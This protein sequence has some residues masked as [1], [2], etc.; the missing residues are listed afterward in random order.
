MASNQLQEENFLD[1]LLLI[2]IQLFDLALLF[3]P[4]AMDQMDVDDAPSTTV[5]GEL[6]VPLHMLYIR[7]ILLAWFP[8]L[9]LTV[10][11]HSNSTSRLCS[12]NCDGAC[13]WSTYASSRKHIWG[14]TPPRR[15]K[16]DLCHLQ[17]TTGV[18]LCQEDDQNTC[19]GGDKRRSSS[20]SCEGTLG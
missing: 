12:W 8:S 13:I 17:N 1:T 7:L 5:S 11:K 16:K 2:A 15:S 4:M 3:I 20:C 19:K 10:F 9:I 18:F 6:V 14:R